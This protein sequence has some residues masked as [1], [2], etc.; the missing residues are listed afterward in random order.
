[1]LMVSLVIDATAIYDSMY[2]ASGPRAVEEKRTAIE[3][4]GIQEGMKRQSAV[5]R[6]VT[7]K[8]TSLMD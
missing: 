5:L 8:R 1:M 4:M 6:C 2:V 7:E 3:M